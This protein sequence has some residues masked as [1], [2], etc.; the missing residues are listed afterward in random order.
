MHLYNF[1]IIGFGSSGKRYA[2]I[3]KKF[4]LKKK[5]FVFSKIKHSFN[6]IK[7]LDEIKKIKFD[8]IFICN[9]TFKHF[10]TLKIIDKYQKN[11]KI[12]IEKPLFSKVENYNSKNNKIYVG[13]NLRFDPIIEY[14][15]NKIKKTDC[16]LY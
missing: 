3:L 1:L 9:E 2:K 12:L 5:I 4:K 10:E 13:Y 15:K 8:M 6:Q 14:L 7:N 11:I 16:K